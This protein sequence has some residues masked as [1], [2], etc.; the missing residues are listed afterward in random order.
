[1]A[2]PL[3]LSK[4]QNSLNGLNTAMIWLTATPLSYN[5]STYSIPSNHTGVLAAAGVFRHPSSLVLS[6]CL[7]GSLFQW[8]TSSTL[9]MISVRFPINLIKIITL[10][11]AVSSYSNFPLFPPTQQDWFIRSPLPPFRVYTS[12]PSVSSVKNSFLLCWLMYPKCLEENLASNRHF[13][14]VYWKKECIAS[15]SCS[16]LHNE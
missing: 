7:E 2:S 1:M 4:S 14:H 11:P 13:I 10:T 12:N 15:I 16:F 5:P 6:L 8:C 3:T 9:C